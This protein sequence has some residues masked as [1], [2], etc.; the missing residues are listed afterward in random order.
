MEAY[1]VDDT[2]MPIRVEHLNLRRSNLRQRPE[3]QSVHHYNWSA[4]RMGRLL[5]SQTLRDLE[6]EQETM[7]NDQ[8]N[9]GQFALHHLYDMPPMPTLEQMMDRLDDAFESNEHMRIRTNG[10][11]VLQSLS[12]IHRIQINQEYNREKD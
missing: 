5:I 1:P 11:W 4:R 9:L 3:N 2:G 7:Q 10:G 12:D 8:H 6:G